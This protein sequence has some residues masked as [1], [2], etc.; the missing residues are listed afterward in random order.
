MSFNQLKVEDIE[1]IFFKI[2]ENACE[3]LEEAEIL[4]THKKY[5]RAY[6]CAHIAFEEFGKLPMLNTV[7][8][9]VY[10]GVK[11]DWKKLNKRMRDHKRKISQSYGTVMFL[12]SALKKYNALYK[13]DTPTEFKATAY[14]IENNWLYVFKEFIEREV[15]INPFE[16]DDFN[17][18]LDVQ[19]EIKEKYS[20]TMLLNEYKNGSLYADFDEG[21][22]KK[23]S[24]KIDKDT[25]EYGISL[26]YMQKKF[27]DA[28]NI[29][30]EGFYL[31]K[32]D[33]EYEERLK[34]GIERYEQ[35]KEK[36]KENN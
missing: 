24:E 1:K 12:D 25:C 28:P 34:E 13:G 32:F 21:E 31:Y 30:K 8:L 10:N 22:F 3:L 18:G 4:Y 29:H 2:Y 16:W 9:N 7:A 5:A 17:K 14:D 19:E 27:I 35:L 36:I 11:T 33:E 23:P 6:L 26:A 20:M 15:V